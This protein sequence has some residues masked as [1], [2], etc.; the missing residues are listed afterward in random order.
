MGVMYP[1]AVHVG[2]Q[3]SQKDAG[4]LLCFSSYCCEAG[5]L[6]VLEA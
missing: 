6:T 5:S 1:C 2:M 3:E 4:C